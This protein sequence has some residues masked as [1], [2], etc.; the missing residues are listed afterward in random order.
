MPVN[1][2]RH[3]VSREVTQIF[4]PTGCACAAGAAADD[5]QHDR[6]KNGAEH[7]A[8]ESGGRLQ[9]PESR[10][11]NPNRSSRLALRRGRPVR[12]LVVMAECAQVGRAFVEERL[13]VGDRPVVNG[14]S[15]FC[16]E[17]SRTSD[18]FKSPTS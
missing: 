1:T 12:K 17:V 4:A 15:E 2:G 9:P 14:R 7:D 5:Q 16:E 18:A 3:A 10:V 8:A 13:R 11:S 6:A